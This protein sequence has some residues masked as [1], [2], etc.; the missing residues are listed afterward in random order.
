MIG[1]GHR[2][3]MMKV[4]GTGERRGAKRGE[5]E[6]H[7]KVEMKILLN[8]SESELATIWGWKQDETAG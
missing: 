8:P 5:E 4:K 1:G 6:G 7:R 2:R 3:C